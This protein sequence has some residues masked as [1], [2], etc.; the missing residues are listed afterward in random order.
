[1]KLKYA[2]PFI[3]L[4]MSSGAAFATCTQPSGVYTGQSAG[5]GYYNGQLSTVGTTTTAIT[6]TS[7]TTGTMFS[8]NRVGPVTQTPTPPQTIELQATFPAP[9]TTVSWVPQYCGGELTVAYTN[10]AAGAVTQTFVYTVINDGAVVT[11]NN[12]SGVYSG[13]LVDGFV[14]T[15]VTRLERP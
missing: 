3:C 12:I 8:I 7:P 11:L 6:F 1:M 15:F 2:L 4:A 13:N 10:P 5:F 14:T 9:N